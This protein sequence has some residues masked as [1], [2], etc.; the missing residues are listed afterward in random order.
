LHIASDTDLESTIVAGN[1]AGDAALPS[2]VGGPAGTLITG[3]DNLVVASTLSLPS[4]TLTLDPML[5]P[6]HYNGGTTRTHALLPG[7]PAIDAGNN[8]VGA[9]YDQRFRSADSG[10]GFERVIGPRADIGAFESGTPDRIFADG[11][12]GL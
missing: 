11:F 8:V 2:D 3:A 4:G 9:H 10:S 1:L 5:G 6:L 7:S 12:D